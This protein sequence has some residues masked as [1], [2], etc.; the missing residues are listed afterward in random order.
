MRASEYYTPENGYDEDSLGDDYEMDVVVYRAAASIIADRLDLMGVT[1]SAACAFLDEELNHH[2]IILASVK[3]EERARIEY[4]TDLFNSLDSGRWLSLLAAAPEGP[5]FDPSPEPGSRLWL[6]EQIDYEGDYSHE[7]HVLRAVLI[8]FPDAEVTLD[9][10]DLVIT[11]LESTGLEPIELN[12]S[13][14]PEDHRLP[15][16]A[17]DAAAAIR[18][19]AAVN[20]P[21]VVLTEGRTDAEFLTA[22]LKVLYPHLTDLIRFL[23]YDY[24]PEGGV[25]ALVRMIRAFTAAGIVNRVVAVFDNDTAAADGLKSLKISRLPAHIRV[26]SY[27]PMDL[28]VSY[29]TLGPPTVNSPHGSLS[30]ADVN[31]SAGSIELYLG[32]DVLTREDGTLR[33]VQWKSFIPGMARYQGEVIEKGLL[34]TLFRAKYAMAL[35]NPAIVQAQDWEG[36]RLVIDAIRAAAQEGAI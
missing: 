8:A 21:V 28:A 14:G 20:A 26:I 2:R 25:D 31:G 16:M 15:W 23:D 24:R 6:L 29:P 22:G 30:L 35:E 17:C 27:P 13:E 18:R 4:E 32:K 3:G 19:A 12:L 34:H 5:A 33:P 11:E 36:L 10:T 7:R 9:L 1:P